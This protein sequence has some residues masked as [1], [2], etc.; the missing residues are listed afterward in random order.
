VLSSAYRQVSDE[1]PVLAKI[2]PGNSLFGRMNRRRLSVEQWR[3]S[4]LWAAGNLEPVGGRSLELDDPENHRRTV[5]ARVSRLKLNDFLALFDYPDANVH[6]EDRAVTT[7]PT[8]K[9]FLLNSP[10]VIEQ[11]KALAARLAVDSG[12]TD[13]DRV[14]RAYGLLLSREPDAE[15]LGLALDYLRLP[16]SPEMSRW[17]QYAQV[18]MVSNELLYVD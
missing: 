7:T 15:E 12:Q 9:L 3:D 13:A 2:D 10:F 14:R 16:D 6:A 8:Q 5:Y 1:N 4:V 17:D 18:L 11:A